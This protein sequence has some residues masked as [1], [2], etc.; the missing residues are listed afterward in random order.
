MISEDARLWVD[1]NVRLLM[2]IFFVVSTVISFVLYA[3]KVNVFKIVILL[4]TFALAMAFA[5]ND[6]VNFIGVPLAGLDSFN[7]WRNA[8]S[9][10][11]DSFMMTSLMSSAK[12]SVGYL[13]AAGIVMILALVF[14]KKAMA[15][16]KTGV[17][18]SRQDSSDEMFGSSRAARSIVRNT[19]AFFSWL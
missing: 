16:V 8:G 6:L 9:P 10:D 5:G 11:V 14:S 4:G 18:L 17:D 3:L 19:E 1:S 15:V 7:E 12:S 2:L 13:I